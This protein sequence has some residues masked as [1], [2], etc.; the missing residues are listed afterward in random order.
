M[1]HCAQWMGLLLL[2]LSHS[3]MTSQ[4]TLSFPAPSSSDTIA[5]K[6]TPLYESLDAALEALE[7]EQAVYRLDLSRHRLKSVPP[8]LLSF[9]DLR[10]LRL[11]HNKLTDLPS[12]MSLL[13]HLEQ[14]Y[15]ASNRLTAFP[16]SYLDW[17]AMTHLD[18]GNNFIDSIPIDIDALTELEYLILWGNVIRVFPA[19]IGQ[20]KHLLVLDLLHNDMTIAEQDL[21]LTWVFDS[22]EVLLS[23]PCRCEFDD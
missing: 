7:R 13:I 19:S 23:P 15:V 4:E 12:E 11:D 16:S 8:E 9:T 1:I 18:L 22:T 6:N 3:A 10:E 2:C 17:S 5:W 21:L 14:L 20:F